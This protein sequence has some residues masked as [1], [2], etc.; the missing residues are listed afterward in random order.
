[1]PGPTPSWWTSRDRQDASPCRAL[2][3]PSAYPRAD[4]RD[5][6][7][8]TERAL[9]SAAFLAQHGLQLPCTEK[10]HILL[11]KLNDLAPIWYQVPAIR[12]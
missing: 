11:C 10:L 9:E 7:W 1:M 8:T 6:R 3:A 2:V 4:V 12:S 5:L